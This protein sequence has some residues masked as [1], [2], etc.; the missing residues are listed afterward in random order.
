[1][2]PRCIKRRRRWGEKK[3]GQGEGREGGRA[4]AKIGK[5]G[6]RLPILH[7][8]A[9][10]V[11]TANSFSYVD[12][13]SSS[14]SSFFSSPFPPFVSPSSVFHEEEGFG[15]DQARNQTPIAGRRRTGRRGRGRGREVGGWGWQQDSVAVIVESFKKR[16]AS[17]V[18]SL[19]FQ[20]EEMRGMRRLFGV[21]GLKCRQGKES[22][23]AKGVGK[24]GGWRGGGRNKGK[25]R[26]RERGGEQG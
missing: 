20:Q 25:E 11:A 9:R 18:R 7:V 21:G 23:G 17:A 4:G 16:S 22:G 6:K 12:L 15:A 5:V 8:H 10:F 24:R 14:P 26:G 2:R 3:D 19:Q 1:L 13:S